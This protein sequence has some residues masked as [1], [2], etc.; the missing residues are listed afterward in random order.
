M[1]QAPSVELGNS[2]SYQDKLLAL[3]GDRDPIDVLSTSPTTIRKFAASHPAEPREPLAHPERR[4]RDEQHERH[5]QRRSPAEPQVAG[6]AEG[7]AL[8]ARES[9][10]GVE[11]GPTARPGRR[12]RRVRDVGALLLARCAG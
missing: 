3:L 2:K 8:L 7:A 6:R 10:V 1:T 4:R 9:A 12:R 5:E 11:V